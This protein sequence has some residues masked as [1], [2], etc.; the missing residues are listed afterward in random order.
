M[1][2]NN[3]SSIY[4]RFTE[5][6]PKVFQVFDGYGHVHYF[7]YIPDPSVSRIKF[8]MPVRGNYTF[9]VPIEIVKVVPIEI[10]D[11]V[12]NP[13]LPTP[14][15]DLWKPIRYQY[16]KDLDTVARI[17]PET[18]LILHGPRYNE[19]SK[20]MQIFIDEHEKDRKSVV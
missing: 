3:P 17:Y 5:G 4:I 8:R 6:T 18:G 12:K 20:P 19:L 15:R 9:N 16:K 14:E 2:V 7:R 1:L 11:Y 13:K 10:P